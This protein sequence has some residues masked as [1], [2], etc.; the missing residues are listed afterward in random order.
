[1]ADI[2]ANEDLVYAPGEWFCAKC[3][4]RGHQRTLYAQTG[5]V[6]V[7]RR[8]SDPC[9]NDD[10]PLERVTWRQDAEE[11]NQIAMDL[12][13][14]NRKLRLRLEDLIGAH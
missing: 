7:N 9:P 12:V 6:G 10:T 13:K 11:A 2:T 3:G 1:M 4:F 8:E 5:A 14:E